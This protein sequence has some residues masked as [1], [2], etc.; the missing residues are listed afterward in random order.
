MHTRRSAILTL[1]A[2]M[3]TLATRT[4]RSLAA[5]P[6]DGQTITY[7]VATKA[8]GGYDTMGRLVAKYLE[9]HLEGVEVRVKNMPG[10][11]HVVGALEIFN[12][13][14]DALTI[15][16]FNSGL[17]YAQLLGELSPPLDLQKFNWIGKA[18][19]ETRV[20]VAGANTPF[21]TVDDLRQIGRP[22]R[23]AA[24]GVRAASYFDTAILAK[25]L[26]FAV[27]I[28]PG[29]E[30]KEGELS[31]MRGEIDCIVGSA[32]AL[33]PFVRNGFGRAIV[34]V[35][36]STGSDIPEA[37]SFAGTDDA[38]ALIALVSSQAQLSRLTAA[39]PG[40]DPLR[41]AAL[42]KAYM[43]ALSDPKFLEDASTLDLPIAPMD[44]EQVAAAVNKALNPKNELIAE[45]KQLLPAE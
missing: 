28:I 22:I 42:R 6:F 4:R 43:E 9:K 31:L 17:L 45:I 33:L 14:P 44:G 11:S 19:I 12:A 35:G 37:N 7:I 5:S 2:A 20:L 10:G 40:T 8:G 25:A 18:A 30:G 34:Q 1:S 15:G 24:S 26:G 36:D 13:A 32:S 41:L 23:C 29:F 27:D 38:K 3:T 21:N 39:P 16:T